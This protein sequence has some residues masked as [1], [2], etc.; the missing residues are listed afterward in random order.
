MMVRKTFIHTL[1]AVLGVVVFNGGVLGETSASKSAK[2]QPPRKDLGRVL[3]RSYH[4]KEAGKDMQY[5]MYFP[6]YY[7]GQVKWPL[8]VALHGLGSSP[9]QMMRYA[10]LTKM[11]EHYGYVV[12]APMGYNQAGWYGS[13]SP[14]GRSTVPPNLYELSEKD[15]MNV[16][17][18]VRDQYNI[19]SSRLYLMG[20]SMGGGGA[21]HLAI[22]YPHL[23]AGIAPIAPAIYRSPNAL[24]KITH[25]PVIMVQGDADKL[26][27]VGIARN[28]AQKMK[29]LKMEHRYIEVPKGDHMRVAFDNMPAI[30]AY[31]DRFGKKPDSSK[32]GK[33]KTR[34]AV[35]SEVQQ[36]EQHLQCLP[37]QVAEPPVI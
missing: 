19:D 37:V 33:R 3:T 1:L 20:H 29:Q 28:W 18:R 36:A 14:F 4:F 2:I 5:T 11:A 13:S 12:V 22:K 7:D 9:Q 24:E 25:I 10:N 26:V 35:E 21:L 32:T 31:L 34:K 23:W 6:S 27:P 16:L 8:M 17:Q 30:F 15:V